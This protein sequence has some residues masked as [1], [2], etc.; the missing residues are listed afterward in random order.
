MIQ[1][2]PDYE[3]FLHRRYREWAI[4]VDING[5][6]YGTDSIVEFSIENSLINNDEFEIGTAVISRLVLK[7]KT[8]DEI[9]ANAKV[10]P[11]LALSSAS[12]TWQTADIA[13]EDADFSWDGGHTDWLPLGEFYID[14]RSQQRNIWT[15]ECFDKLVW[16]DVAYVSELNYPT[17]MQAVW[18]EICNQVG[19]TYDDSVVIDPTYMINAGPAGF[20][21][22]QVLGYIAGANAASIYV[23]RDGTIK[24]KRYEADY[25]P[26]YELTEADYMRVKQTNPIKT[27][28]RVVVTYDIDDQLTYEAGSGDE[29]HTLH[30]ENPFMTQSM[31]NDLLA[32]LDGFTYV[33]IQ[34]D[35]RGYP[36]LEAGDAISYL[37]QESVSWMDADFAWEDADLAW[38]GLVRYQTLILEQTFTFRG[39]LKMTID[40]PSKSEQESEFGIDGSLTAAVKRLNE[41]AVRYGKP[42]YGVTHSRTEGIV[43]QREDGL[44]KAVFNADELSFY[45]DGSRALWFDVPNERWMFT[46]TLVG[47][48]GEFTGTL[49]AA[50]INGSV[51]NGGEIYGSYIEGAEIDAGELYGSYIEGGQITGAF[52]DGGQITGS[53]ID[54]GQ[55]TGALI[56]TRGAGQYP[57]I[58]FSST[59][60]L[61]LAEA[62]SGSSLAI[63]AVY[64][65]YPSFVFRSNGSL[66]GYVYSSS[67]EL[68][69]ATFGGLD[70]L[71]SA[72]SDIVLSGDQIRVPR[73]SDLYSNG[74]G[75]SLRSALNNKADVDDIDDLWDEIDAIWNYL[76]L[77]T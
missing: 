21:A 64:N 9:P 7:I 25:E 32:K 11:Y 35:A 27:Y 47:V 40:A 20:T 68:L 73:W 46:G 17:T 1:I 37:R 55:I 14:N 2:T 49:T 45:A 48:D 23:G 65:G 8:Y 75:E 53:F 26:V 29:N 72:S 5:V 41:N 59:S 54:G 51:I 63:H 3:T 61:L 57:R 77:N 36:Q 62:N 38:D 22:R 34:M 50:V 16:A 15:F 43:V 13:W 69:V 67:N 10:V 30:V 74:D 6:E 66:A 42:Y 12:L 28:T 24:W 58:E 31:V 56:Q 39:G 60:S 71:L 52:I 4:K 70:L 19:F 18:D 44:A 76:A 33:P